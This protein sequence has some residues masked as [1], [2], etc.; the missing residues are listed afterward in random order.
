MV[1]NRYMCQ[2][3]P[4]QLMQYSSCP[5]DFTDKIIMIEII[6][7]FTLFLTFK[8]F[9]ITAASV[10]INCFIVPLSVPSC[11]RADVIRIIS[12]P[13]SGEF[14]GLTDTP[15]SWSCEELKN[16][17]PKVQDVLST[18]IF[19]FVEICSSF[20]VNNQCCTCT[21]NATFFWIR[22]AKNNK[23]WSFTL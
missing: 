23:F 3:S 18:L 1:S 22:I 16:V 12:E 21:Y 19:L 2:W 11:S 10:L 6:S 9:I 8:F 5:N 4:F 14:F 17:R 15:E 7:H 13:S 20:L